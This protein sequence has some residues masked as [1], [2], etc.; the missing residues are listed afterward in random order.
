[1]V[2]RIIVCRTIIIFTE[3]I[4]IAAQK[5][6]KSQY[7]TNRSITAEEVRLIGTDGTAIGIMSVDE[8]LKHSEAAGLDLVEISPNA[9]PP[10]CRI[11]DYGKFMF[12]I[13]KREK[14][15]KKKQK[16][17]ELKEI[18][19]KLGIDE[20]DINFKIKNACKFLADGNKVKVSL[21]FRGREMTRTQMGAEVLEKFTEACSEYGTPEKEPKLEGR[22]MIVIIAP[23]KQ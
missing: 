20:H 9:R 12:E 19:L 18:W 5:G 4:T 13:S 2:L 1:V 15:A 16:T 14:E 23:K 21:S 7:R 6:T 11:M 17:M 8:A 3:V 10:V 22:H